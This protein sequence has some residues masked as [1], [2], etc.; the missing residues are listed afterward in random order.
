MMTAVVSAQSAGT[1]LTAQHR[2]A[3]SPNVGQGSVASRQEARPTAR[4]ELAANRPMGN[5]IQVMRGVL[6]NNANLIFDVQQ[7]DPGAP[8]KAGRNEE[9]A[10]QTR[11]FANVYSGWQVVEN[12]AVALDE[13]VD[14]ILKAGRIC[15][16]GTPVPVT[17]SDYLKTAQGLRETAREILKAAQQRNRDKV[18]DLA[19]DLAEACASCHQIYRDPEGPKG[20]GDTSLRCKVPQ[21]SK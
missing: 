8:I 18:T 21:N 6:F 11:N 4:K 3:T 19:G 10:T 12:A 5:L 9:G 13:S 7:V 15:Q 16:N 17:Q 14:T 2:R 20:F 1:S